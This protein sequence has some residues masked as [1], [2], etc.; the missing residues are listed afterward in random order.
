MKHARFSTVY[1]DGCYPSLH[2]VSHGKKYV[3]KTFQTTILNSDTLVTTSSKIKTIFATWYSFIYSPSVESLSFHWILTIPLTIIRTHA[4]YRYSQISMST[5][6]PLVTLTICP[7]R[8]IPLIHLLSFLLLS[9]RSLIKLSLRLYRSPL[10]RPTGL[11]WWIR[12]FIH[13]SPLT[14]LMLICRI[15]L[16]YHHLSTFHLLNQFHSPSYLLKLIES[17]QFSLQG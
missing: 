13:Y 9:C 5:H 2:T 11:I 6:N 3:R 4:N 14:L 12:S 7:N 17:F 1:I 10:I 8:R 15:F 16:S